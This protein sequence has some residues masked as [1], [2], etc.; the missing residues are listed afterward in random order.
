[1]SNKLIEGK[2]VCTEHKPLT[3]SNYGYQKDTNLKGT[4][5]RKT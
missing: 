2:K 4:K 3:L 5:V 1:M